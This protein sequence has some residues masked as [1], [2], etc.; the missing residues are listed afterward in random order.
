MIWKLYNK[1]KQSIRDNRKRLEY[2]FALVAAY[3]CL[4]FLMKRII[5]DIL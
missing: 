3:E 1:R 5:K 2:I 4:N